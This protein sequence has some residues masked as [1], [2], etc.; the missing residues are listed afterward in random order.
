MSRSVTVSFGSSVFE[1]HHK[2]KA[3]AL[4]AAAFVVPHYQYQGL[5]LVI[6]AVRMV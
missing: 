3:A 6:T 1:H 4:R 5:P 2:R